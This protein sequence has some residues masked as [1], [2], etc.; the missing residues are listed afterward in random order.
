MHI[1]IKYYLTNYKPPVD[2]QEFSFD[3]VNIIYTSNVQIRIENKSQ[4][5]AYT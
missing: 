5:F 2:H 1:A 4:Y 3:Y